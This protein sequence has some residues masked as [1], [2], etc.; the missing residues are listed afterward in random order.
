MDRDAT[1]LCAHH[2]ALA[3]MNA[4]ADLDPVLT[5]GVPD[6]ERARHGARGAVEGREEAV[7]GVVDLT[8]AMALEL[9]SHCRMVAFEHAT[10][11]RVA[12]RERLLRRSDDVGI[13]DRGEHAVRV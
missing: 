2:L 4:G 11:L 5:H 3:G 13:E 8:A 7:A 6:G 1:E 10:P 12:Q 9:A